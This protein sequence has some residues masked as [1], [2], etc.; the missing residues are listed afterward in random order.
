MTSKRMSDKTVPETVPLREPA[1]APNHL[2]RVEHPESR[3]HI[4]T[5]YALARRMGAKIL[6]Q[7]ATDQYGHRLPATPRKKIEGEPS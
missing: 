1:Y 7:P 4:T 3:D 6:N 5:T 2:V